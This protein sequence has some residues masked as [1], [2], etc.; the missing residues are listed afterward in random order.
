MGLRFPENL[1]VILRKKISVSGKNRVKQKNLNA[2]Q[3]E[4]Y[5]IQN[6]IQVTLV[7]IK[8]E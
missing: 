1:D 7:L 8:N 5:T 6:D 2:R 4:N 3:M